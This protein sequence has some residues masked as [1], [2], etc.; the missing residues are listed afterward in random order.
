M[1]LA[2]IHLGGLCLGDSPPF[3]QFLLSYSVLSFARLAK[4]I[5]R[6]IIYACK[7][8]ACIFTVYRFPW[9]MAFPRL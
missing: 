6:I 8:L 1:W 3:Q 9:H 4:K 2:A 5:E 7:Q